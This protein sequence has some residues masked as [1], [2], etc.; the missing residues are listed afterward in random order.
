MGFEWVWH[1]RNG[2]IPDTTCLV[3]YNENKKLSGNP[4]TQE[5]RNPRKTKMTGLFTIHIIQPLLRSH[6]HNNSYPIIQTIIQTLP[7]FEKKKKC[8][9]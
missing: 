8:F 3:Y 9:Y 7:E 2:M 1:E 4:Q 6:T 5:K